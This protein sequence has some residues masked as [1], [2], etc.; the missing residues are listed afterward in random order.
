MSVARLRRLWLLERL[1]AL[2]EASRVASA[3][4]SR[5]RADVASLA[6]RRSSRALG[7]RAIFRARFGGEQ[8]TKIVFEDG[9]ISIERLDVPPDCLPESVEGWLSAHP[10][11]QMRQGGVGARGA[12]RRG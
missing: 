5:A 4:I 7:A 8:G 12:H 11:F 6:V 3:V 9:A 1:G 2:P 10:P